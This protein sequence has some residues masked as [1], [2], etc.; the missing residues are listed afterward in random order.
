[1]TDAPLPGASP[2]FLPVLFSG[3]LR[4]FTSCAHFPARPRIKV[5]SQIMPI[6]RIVS[7]FVFIL[8]A[9]SFAF[10]HKV[11]VDYDH[12]ANFSK[13][14]TFMWI[15]KPQTEN[16]IMDDRVVDDVNYQLSS[17]GLEPVTTDADLS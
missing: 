11:R 10:A 2:R 5:T 15:E 13:Y 9:T 12:N 1:M 14:K 7:V 3:S 6:P 4:I 16:P 17:K 8:F